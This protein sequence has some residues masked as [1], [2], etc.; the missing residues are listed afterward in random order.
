MNQEFE[1][2]Y[3]TSLDYR[4]GVAAADRGEPDDKAQ[5]Y[6]WRQGWEDWHKSNDQTDKSN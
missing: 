3:R 2:L 6:L 5:S 1:E 4:N